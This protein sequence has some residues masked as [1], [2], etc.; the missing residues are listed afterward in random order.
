MHERVVAGAGGLGSVSF[1]FSRGD[2]TETKPDVI[3]GKPGVDDPAFDPGGVPADP[4]G[5]P[6]Q[7][8]PGR[9]FDPNCPT[10]RP[11]KPCNP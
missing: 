3:P 1:K 10:T 6:D 2:G 8:K 5:P 9:R 7:D 4:G 11:G